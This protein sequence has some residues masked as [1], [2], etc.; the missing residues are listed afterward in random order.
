MDQRGAGRALLIICPVKAEHIARD[1]IPEAFVSNITRNIE[2]N[3]IS[4]RRDLLSISVFMP[5]AAGIRP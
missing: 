5:D 4:A 2:S 1:N 3:D